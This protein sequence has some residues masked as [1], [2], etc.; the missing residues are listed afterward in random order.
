VV[1]IGHSLGASFLLRYLSQKD[2]D[3]SVSCA[4]L[5]AAPYF[6]MDSQEGDSFRFDEEELP[7]LAQKVKKLVLMHSKDDTVVP[8][9]H[10][11]KLSKVFPEAETI[12]FN[13]RGHFNQESFPELIAHIKGLG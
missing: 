4:Y 11:E 9:G 2:L 8:F 12:V 5:I 13:E 7:A 6:G 1:L 10:L 3:I